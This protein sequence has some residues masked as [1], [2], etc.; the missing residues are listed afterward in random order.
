MFE[1]FN[2]CD[3]LDVDAFIRETTFTIWD[4]RMVGAIYDCYTEDTVIHAA[5]GAEVRGADKIVAD[6][7][8]W[9][10]AFPDLRI[11][12]LNVIWSGNAQD[13]YHASMPWIYHGTNTGYSRF[14]APTGKKL[15]ATNNLGIANTFIQK[16]DGR[17][18]YVEEWST[19]DH[20]AMELVCTPD[21]E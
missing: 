1:H 7:M 15:D 20:K 12:I 6:T 18:I 3:E 16:V 14:G 11:E 9:M 10:S 19:Y 21:A 17:W 2:Q 4:K 8:G 13:G 5:A